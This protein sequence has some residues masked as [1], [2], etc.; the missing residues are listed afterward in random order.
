[1][2]SDRV[3]TGL[4]GGRRA[5]GI[6]LASLLLGACPRTEARG[7]D[8]DGN[9]VDPVTP[10]TVTALVFV[11]AKCP[12]SNRYAPEV[13]RIHGRFGPRGVAFELVYAGRTDTA[14]AVRE[15]MASYGYTRRALRD[16]DHALVRR[17]GATVT[18]EVAV[19]GR[20]RELVYRGRID[21]RQV[22]FGV[23]RPEATRHD[24]E[25]ALEDALADRRGPAR[26]V[27]AVGCSIGPP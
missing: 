11:G 1:M 22:D 25:D 21:D 3:S 18:P 13:R 27:P 4:G 16:P 5:A 17:A 23:A 2:C 14:P 7:L 10:G 15:H 20:R 12:V 19:F 6:A 9:A 26:I 8:L 24:L